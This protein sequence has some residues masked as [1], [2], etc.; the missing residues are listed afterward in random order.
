MAKEK[1]VKTA[2]KYDNTK[3]FIEQGIDIDR[4]RIMIDEEI[5]EYSVGWAIRGVFKMI[6]ADHEK[7]I[8]IYISSYGGSVYEAFGLYDTLRSLKNVIVR[9]HAIGKVM[10]AGF[11]LFLAG[12]ERYCSSRTTL[13]MHSISSGMQGKLHELRV[14]MKETERLQGMMLDILAERTK[15]DR[16]HWKKEIESKDN[17]YNKEQAKL[18]GVV[19]HEE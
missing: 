3:F 16:H 8:D 9:T 15:K 13:M 1:I 5:D 12:D 6:D 10:S 14:D 11:I 17:Y 18:L 7:P 4:R 2:E 19:T